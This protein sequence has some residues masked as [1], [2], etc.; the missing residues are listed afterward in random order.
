ML[1]KNIKAKLYL[2]DNTMFRIRPKRQTDDI[3]SPRYLARSVRRTTL[4]HEI[5]CP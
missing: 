5:T 1:S 2:I 4:T 3:I